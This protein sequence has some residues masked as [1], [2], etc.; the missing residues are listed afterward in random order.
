MVLQ[1]NSIKD[2]NKG[3]IV[4]ELKTGNQSKKITHLSTS[5]QLDDLK[6]T[7][8]T[9]TELQE[10]SINIT[11][12]GSHNIEVQLP[13]IESFLVSANEET[14]SFMIYEFGPNNYYPW[15]NGRYIFKVIIND[16]KYYGVLHVESKNMTED[17]FTNMHQYLER[18]LSGI[19]R[20]YTNLTKVIDDTLDNDTSANQLEHWLLSNVQKLIS[21]LNS[22]E[23]NHVTIFQKTYQVE[24]LPKHLD[25]KSIQWV[26]GAKGSIFAGQKYY[27]RKS[28]LTTNSAE[29]RYIKMCTMV[30]LKALKKTKKKQFKK[31]QLIN[32]KIS[33]LKDR[34]KRIEKAIQQSDGRRNISREDIRKRRLS[35]INAERDL[36]G[37]C[38]IQHNLLI[39]Y[40]YLRNSFK[41][42]NYLMHNTFWKFV[43]YSQCRNV[44][45]TNRNYIPFHKL[46]TEFLNVQGDISTKKKKQKH[47]TKTYMMNSTPTLYEYY[48]FFQLIDILKGMGFERHNQNKSLKEGYLFSEILPNTALQFAKDDLRIDLVYEQE[49]SYGAREAINSKTYFFSGSANRRPDIRID[50]YI[51][52]GR[53][54]EYLYNSSIILEVKYRPLYNIYSDLGYTN[55]MNQLNEYRLIRRYCPFRKSYIDGIRNVICVYPGY[56]RDIH[57]ESEAGSYLILRPNREKE[58]QRYME[59][60]ISKW[61]EGTMRIM[62]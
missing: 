57:F 60:D 45:I 39:N 7:E 43:S 30:I 10:I 32:E 55:E 14:K 17:E 41:Q 44:K 48:S 47:R 33:H 9:V 5:K 26:N 8:I 62:L 56:S 18:H 13:E 58:F 40:N 59:D 20:K 2:L 15:S 52:D 4:I 16:Q 54:N 1:T 61:M 51:Y 25:R 27:N 50:L 35:K 38:E 49:V 46:W 22:I 28:Q 53:F 19:S 6:N 36:N 23:S 21:I 3:N 11:Q 34:I 24:K 12:N 31:N 37:K 29:N 42:I